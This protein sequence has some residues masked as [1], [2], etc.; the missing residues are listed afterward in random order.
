MELKKEYTV[1]ILG[2]GQLGQMIWYAAQKLS[3]K[4]GITITVVFLCKE[5]DLCTS[6]D[7]QIGD[8]NRYS[9]VYNFGLRLK[10]VE[11]AVLSIEIEECNLM[12]LMQLE[13]EGVVVYPS[14]SSLESIQ[15]KYKQISRLN[16]G[17]IPVPRF[18]LC[19]NRQELINFYR[20][21]AASIIWKPKMGGRDGLGIRVVNNQ[22]DSAKIPNA[23]PGV[24][25]PLLDIAKEVSV[26]VARNAKGITRCSP[27]FETIQDSETHCLH[28]LKY[29]QDDELQN[30]KALYQI[31]ANNSVV[32]L[33]IIGLAAVEMFL[34]SNGAILV[35]EVAPRLH[36]SGHLT[37]EFANFSQGEMYLR[38]ILD[39][40]L[41][42]WQ[43]DFPEALL[44]NI[45]GPDDLSGEYSFKGIWEFMEYS[46]NMKNTSIDC[47]IYK[48]STTRPGRK[49]AH[50]AFAGPD[51]SALE[52]ALA[53]YNKMVSVTQM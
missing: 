19:K 42:D 52:D 34:L 16:Y 48:K 18:T 41:P 23:I 38:A 50:I 8:I 6:F 3:K 20:D 2:G 10:G 32:S 11:N 40:E 1:Y 35:N 47:N 53:V 45:V 4:L 44:Q 49:L 51:A 33:D 12:A 27:V 26:L 29:S 17:R 39:L 5:D 21:V 30:N 14:S 37:N 31:I 15:D 7:H 43:M 13:E 9:D 28:Y 22:A 36:N 24:A 46:N 25:Q